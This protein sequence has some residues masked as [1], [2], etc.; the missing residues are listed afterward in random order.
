MTSLLIIFVFGYIL[1]TISDV[2]KDFVL[3]RI[4]RR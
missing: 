1:L 3:E 4:S 2:I